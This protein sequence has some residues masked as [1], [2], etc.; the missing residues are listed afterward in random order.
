MQNP[1]LRLDLGALSA[2]GFLE[3]LSGTDLWRYEALL[4]APRTRASRLRVGGTPLLDLGTGD[5]GVRLLAKDE[6]RN[7]SGSLKDRATE[8]ALAVAEEQGYARVVG[9]STGNAG[10]SLACVAAA[11]G[12]AAKVVVP[13]AAPPSKLAQIRAYGA[14]LVKIDG[15]YDDAFDAALEIAAR[16]RAFCRNTGVNPYVRE[17]KKTCALEIAEQL[18]WRAPDWVVVPCGDGNLLAGIGTGFLELVRLG[19][20]AAPPRL[21]AAQARTSDSIARTFA[22][23]VDEGQVPAVPVPVT[24]ATRADSIAVGRPRDHVGAIRALLD[25]GGLPVVVDDAEIMAARRDLARGFGLWVEPAAA[26][27]L[28]ALGALRDEGTVAAGET[29]VLV[30]TGAGLKDPEA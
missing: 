8:V 24:P 20:I 23:A 27:G 9:A 1:V 30:L 5:N 14:D 10:A 2:A 19:V 6:T 25:C 29:V 7:P 16:E 22:I 28:A 4:P 15:T 17:G 18:G 11:R 3:S 21:V 12:M 13:A 26:A